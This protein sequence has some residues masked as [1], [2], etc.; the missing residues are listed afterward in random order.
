MTHLEIF[1][2]L[3]ALVFYSANVGTALSGQHTTQVSLSF[4]RMLIG[5]GYPPLSYCLKLV[6]PS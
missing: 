4:T 2:L 1:E 5:Q 3:C 6:F